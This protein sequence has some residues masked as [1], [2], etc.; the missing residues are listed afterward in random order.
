MTTRER[1]IISTAVV[2][3]LIVFGFMLALKMAP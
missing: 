2:V 1:E 3:G